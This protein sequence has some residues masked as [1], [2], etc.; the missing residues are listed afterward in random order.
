[1]TQSGEVSVEKLL[2]DPYNSDQEVVGRT[3][4]SLSPLRLLSV[5][6]SC[7]KQKSEVSLQRN[8]RKR[9]RQKMRKRERRRSMGSLSR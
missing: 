1:M 2:A 8:W 5:L 7:Q 9:K 3:F 4:H 6:W